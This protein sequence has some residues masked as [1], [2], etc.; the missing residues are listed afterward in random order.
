MCIRDR[1]LRTLRFD[2]F[3][4]GLD[5]MIPPMALLVML[6]VAVIAACVAAALL[7]ASPAGAY[8]AV[9]TFCMV[10][11]AV[12]AAWAKFGRQTIPARYLLAI[13]FYLAWKVPLYGAF[14]LRRGQKSW[15]RTERTV[16][17]SDATEDSAD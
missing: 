14:L 17:D 10:T 12:L 3:A 2:L 8:L 13:P 7:G 5:L 15:Q 1:G 9:G 16:D 6:L 4:M 11:A